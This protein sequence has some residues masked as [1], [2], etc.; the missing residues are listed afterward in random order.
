MRSTVN[1]I[2][3]I[4]VL[5]FLF[6]LSNCE[7]STNPI[8]L[9]E[10]IAV[11]AYLYAGEAVNDI[12][13]NSTIPLDVDTSYAP[14]IND[15]EVFLIKNDEIYELESSPGDS[16]YYHYSGNDLNVVSGDK[17]RLH[18]LYQ[19]HEINAETIVPDPPNQIELSN[20]ELKVPDFENV[21]RSTI[22]DWIENGEMS[23]DVSWEGSSNSWYYV[24]LENIE[25]NPEEIETFK[26]DRF[27]LRV[28]P[29]IQDTSYQIRQ[30]S[31]THIGEHK[32]NVYAVNIEYA[33]LYSSREQDSRDLQEPLTNIEGGL[34][35]FTSFAAD[36]AFFTVKKAS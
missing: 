10:S 24:T 20:S 32:I 7:E 17:F 35:V 27:R 11:Q 36:T 34:G 29:P 22:M 16:G 19:E 26:F 31:L 18:I 23:I 30:P 6:F 5:F 12:R 21:D 25:E 15:A 9:E 33:N 28:F 13:L 1:K 2:S 8:S 3:L 4:S 14:P